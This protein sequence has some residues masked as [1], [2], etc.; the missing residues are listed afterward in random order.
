MSLNA[1]EAR[2]QRGLVMHALQ[3]QWPHCLVEM[4]LT[5]QVQALIPDPRDLERALAYLQQR[6]LVELVEERVGER[7]IRTF[8]LTSDGV[9]VAEGTQADAGVDLGR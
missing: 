1:F 3:A 5:R 2:L 9:L 6:K 7:R 4:S 8:R